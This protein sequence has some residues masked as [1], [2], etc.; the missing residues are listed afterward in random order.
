YKQSRKELEKM[1]ENLGDS[2]HEIENDKPII[3]SMI[4][5]ISRIIEWIETGRNPYY[6]QGMDVRYAYDITR[7]PYM[8][9]LPDLRDHLT[10]ESKPPEI[11]DEHIEI[12]KRVISVLSDREWECFVLHNASCMSMSEIAD[13]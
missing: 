12:F 7:L 13:K 10:E 4:N 9:I 8:D 1:L 3:N 11:T 5:S 2:Y 6:Q